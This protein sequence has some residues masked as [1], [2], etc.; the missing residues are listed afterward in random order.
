[1]NR[2]LIL[3]LLGACKHTPADEHAWWCWPESVCFG[4]EQ[5]CRHA[6]EYLPEGER[7]EPHATAFC[8]HGCTKSEAGEP[9]CAPHCGVSRDVCAIEPATASTCREDPPPKHPD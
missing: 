9:L 6:A 5:D 2:V 8:T 4:S 1:M 3:A 7:C